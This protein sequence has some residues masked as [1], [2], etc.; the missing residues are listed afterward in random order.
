MCS[1]VKFYKTAMG[2]SI[3]PI[4]GAD[5]WLAGADPEA[6]LSRICFLAMD[7]KGYRNLTELISRGWTDG[8]RNGLVIL[9]R[10][11]IAPASEGLIALSAG[12][13]GD[14]GMALLAGGKT[15]PKRFFK[16]GWACSPSASTLKCSAP[17]GHA[18]KNTCTR[19]WHWPTSLAPRWWLPTTYVS[20]SRRTSTPTRPAYAL[21]RM[22]P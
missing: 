20:S 5:L 7:P 22:D 18:T 13:E 9:Q 4:C 1:L 14:I 17:I 15:K 10:E 16:T 11:W 6:P 21:A 2:V 19:R 8:Q 12:K 3:K